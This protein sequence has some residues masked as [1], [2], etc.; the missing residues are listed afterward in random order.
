MAKKNKNTQDRKREQ[1]ARRADNSFAR[2]GEA[3]SPHRQRR[4]P[5]RSYVTQGEP[6]R[7]EKNQRTI[8]QC[9]K[10]NIVVMEG[11]VTCLKCGKR[12]KGARVP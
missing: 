2:E 11:R 5:S 10:P 8:C 4:Q 1:E 6:S 7:S 12:P 9:T 3:A